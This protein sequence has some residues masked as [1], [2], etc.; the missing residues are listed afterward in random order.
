MVNFMLVSLFVFSYFFCLC[1][2][3]L[4]KNPVVSAVG[5]MLNVSLLGGFVY[6]V[7]GFAWYSVIL[8]VVYLGGVYV[9]LLYVSAYIQNDYDEDSLDLFVFFCFGFGLFLSLFGTFCFG[10]IWYWGPLDCG[11]LFVCYDLCFVYFLLIGLVLISFFVLCILF[12]S[13]CFYLR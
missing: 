10:F 6:F 3:S 2:F 13:F 5:L 11:E 1:F 12:S 7:L 9:I 8:L 4:F